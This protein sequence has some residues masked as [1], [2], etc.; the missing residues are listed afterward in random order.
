[1]SFFSLRSRVAQ[2]LVGL[3]ALLAC[4]LVPARLDAQEICDFMAPTRSSFTRTLP[5]GESITYLGAPHI[6][7]DDGVEIWA[8]TAVDYSAQGMLHMMG[9][10]RFLDASGELTED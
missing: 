10:V 8:D 4:P 9:A 7:C 5:G 2:A 1:M 6:L 3:T